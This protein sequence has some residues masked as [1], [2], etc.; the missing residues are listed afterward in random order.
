MKVEFNSNNMA[1][2]DGLYEMTKSDFLQHIMGNTAEL[3]TMTVTTA[4]D[5]VKRVSKTLEQET[6]DILRNLGIPVHI[7]GFDYSRFAIM[8]S[9]RD[10]SYIQSITKMLYPAISKEFHTEPSRAERAIRHGIEIA[11][12]RGNVEA[13]KSMFGYSVDVNKGKPTNSE[14]IATISDNLRLRGIPL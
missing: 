3:K 13:I 6:T 8:L 4:P 7:K 11:W 12:S 1:I 10:K 14:F 9:V 2:I 5:E